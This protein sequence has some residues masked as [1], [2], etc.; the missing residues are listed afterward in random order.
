MSKY[1]AAFRFGIVTPNDQ[2]HSN[3]LNSNAVY[4]IAMQMEPDRW[5]ICD[6]LFLFVSKEIQA[7]SSHHFINIKLD[8]FCPMLQWISPFLRI[9]SDSL[10]ILI[11]A[12]S[13]IDSI[14]VLIPNWQ[15]VLSEMNAQ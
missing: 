7:S 14:L 15:E 2:L 4:V 3:W 6:L 10:A 13:F 5:K 8:N 11:L 1:S 12:M 9:S